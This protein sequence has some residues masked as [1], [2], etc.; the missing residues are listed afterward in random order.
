MNFEEESEGV[1]TLETTSVPPCESNP[2]DELSCCGKVSC[3]CGSG[4]ENP[5]VAPG[6]SPYFLRT[7]VRSAVVQVDRIPCEVCGKLFKAGAGMNRHLARTVCGNTD[8]PVELRPCPGNQDSCPQS[9]VVP[10]PVAPCVPGEP[11]SQVNIRDSIRRDEVE[12]QSVCDKL[13]IKWPAMKEAER[14]KQF[15]EGVMVQLPPNASW[16][17]K[18]GRLEDVVY[19]EAKKRFG[20][21]EPVE[22]RTKRK[23]RREVR[24]G[25]LREEIRQV[26]R[27][28]KCVGNEERYGLDLLLYDLKVERS[29]LRWVENHRKRRKERSRLRKGFYKNPFKESK[30]MLSDSKPVAL[31]VEKEVLD[32]YVKGVALDARREEDLGVLEGLP[33]PLPKVVDFDTRPFRFSHFKRVVQNKRPA[34]TPG[35]NKVPYTVYKKCPKIARFLFDIFCSVRRS[36]VVPLCWRLNDGIMIPKVDNPVADQI[37]DFR[38]IAL[39]NVEGKIFWSMVADRL[40]NYLVTQNS[41]VSSKIQKGSMRK[42]AGCWE[43]TA[44]MWSALKDARKRRRSLASVWLDLAN[45]YGSVPHRLIVFALQRYQVPPDWIDLIMAYYD[46]LWGRTSS[47]AVSSEWMRYERGIFAGCTISVVL[48]VAAFNVILEYVGADRRVVGYKMPGGRIEVLRGFMDD[49]SILTESV[50]LAKVAL[51]RTETAV[52]WARMKLKPGKS[53]SFVMKKGM[54]MNVQPFAVGELDADIAKEED[55]IPALQRKPLKTLGRF[56]DPLITDTWYKEVLKEKLLGKLKRLD[57]CHARGAMKLWALHHIVLPQIRWDLMVYEI[58]VSCV[59]K[60][61]G[62]VSK[63]IRFWLGIS[64]N[65]SSVAL[66]SQNSP[67]K[68]PLSSLVHLFK[69]TKLNAHCQLLNSAHEEVVSNVTPAYTGKKWK[70]YNPR[71]VVGITVDFGAVRRAEQRVS[72]VEIVGPVAQGRMGLEFAG[73]RDGKR[74]E[75]LAVRKKLVGT[76]AEDR[77]EE[78]LVKAAHQSVQGRWIGWTNYNQR[79]L[80]WKSLVYGDPKLYR[81]CLGA[82]FDTLGSPA[83]LA[84]WGIKESDKCFLCDCYGIPEDPDKPDKLKG[85]VAHIL[86]GCQVSLAQG[87]WKY[88]HDSVLRVICHHLSLFLIQVK[89]KSN[90]NLVFVPVGASDGNR[91]RAKARAG[92]LRSAV[93]WILL[94]DLGRRLVFP[95]H[96]AQTSQRPDIVLYSSSTQTLVMVELTCPCE[97]NFD[98]QHMKKLDRYDKLKDDCELN[99]WKV[100]LFAVEVGARGYVAHS[101]TSCLKRF[102]LVGKNLRLAVKEAGDE[103]LRTSFWLWLLREELEWKSIGFQQQKR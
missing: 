97:E 74:P 56:Y 29:K 92:L 53:R 30:R 57:R 84:R 98:L 62:T 65:M 81:F 67:C 10:E 85:T 28:M 54:S 27:R 44:M 70:L 76:V 101:L 94:D 49:V 82:T 32:E 46:G 96:I 66:Y 61:E 55:V 31:D 15:E 2:R 35:P 90:D 26:L 36:G 93:D 33:D 91:G 47:P 80:T 7:R 1:S 50:P 69:S 103:A 86:S 75:L 60:L 34:S 20:C 68:L 17:L 5:V 52:A 38:Q 89:R 77:E 25:Q 4:S 64:R 63:Y 102:G 41:F 45:A 11:S 13:P 8:P 12:L 95:A 40:Y 51:K 22:G 71:K 14:W 23:N 99:G 6:R 3:L 43:H 58:P 24:L 19:D 88:R 9:L 100:F 78:L 48:F 73:G 39:L 16:K 42:V 59:E 21:V 37:G 87:R 72:A 79:V 83:N 18:L